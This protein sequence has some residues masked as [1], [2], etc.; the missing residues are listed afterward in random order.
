MIS[1]TNAPPDLVD[2]GA[3]SGTNLATVLQSVLISAVKSATENASEPR[4][5]VATAYFNLDGFDT[6]GEPL[7]QV[8]ELRLLIGTEPNQAFVLTHQLAQELERHFALIRPESQQKLERW[9]AFVRQDK[10]Q[11][12]RYKP[13]KHGEILHGKAYLVF[14]VPI[15]GQLGVIGS[16]NFTGA[17]LTTNLELNAILKQQSAT[18]QLY[19]WYEQLWQQAEDYKAELLAMLEQFTRPLRPY[20]VYI[21]VVYE[22]YRDRLAS[23][24]GEQE[25]RP[26]PIALADFQRDGY[27]AAREI[28]EQYGGVLIADSVGLGKTYLALRLLDDY[29][30]QQR[31]TALVIC[32]AALR[33]TVWKPLLEYH[34]IP[35]RIESMEQISRGDLDLGDLQQYSVIVVDES[36][37]FRNPNANR[38]QNLFQLLRHAS[39]EQ[40]R[41]ILL[42]A[43]PVNNSVYDLYH[44]IRLI[45]RDQKDFFQIAGIDNLESYFRKAEEQRES[46]YELLEAISVRRSRAFIRRRYPDAII[47][48]KRIQFPERHIHTVQYD[49][50]QVYG[51]DLYQRVARTIEELNLAPYQ[52]DSYRKEVVQS[53]L[54]LFGDDWA[55][56]QQALRKAGMSEEQIRKFRFELGGQAALADLMRVLYLKRL[57]SSVEALRNSLRHQLQ[58]Q[59]RFLETLQQGKLLTSQDYRRMLMLEGDDEEEPSED[60]QAFLESLKSTDASQYDLPLV[61][62]A[63]QKDIRTLQTL[64]DELERLSPQNDAKVNTLVNL[65]SSNLQ[66]EKVLIFSYYKDTARMLYSELK[67]RLPHVEIALVDSDVKMEERRRIV[68]RFSPQSNRYTLQSN[69]HEIQILIATDALSEG[70]NLQDA[71]IVINYDLHWNPV[72]MVQ[73]IGRIDRIGSPHKTIDVYNFIPED[74]LEDL[75]GLMQRLL[76]KLGQI[77]RTVGLDAS[78]LGEAP[79]PMD[80]N[81]LRRIAQGEDAVLEALEQEGELNIGEFLMEDLMAY[82]KELGEEHLGRIPLG[83]G[84]AKYA[85]DPNHV[86]FFAAFR[87]TRTERHYWLFQREGGSL[88]T[89]QLRAIQP[90]RSDP[91]EP[92]APL[93]Q[94]DQTEQKLQALRAELVKRLNQQKHRA[95]DL[96]SVQRQILRWLRTLP[97]SAWRNELLQYFGNA[98]PATDLTELRTL[99]REVPKLAP[100]QAMQH[101]KAFAESHPYP[102]VNSTALEETTEEDLECIAWMWVLQRENNP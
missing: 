20:E 7:K 27:Y 14:G 72:R 94:P 63:V 33:D 53:R 59:Q 10:V 2:N 9:A 58:F 78:V 48:G 22:A 13:Q 11:V 42:T 40:T 5:W 12:R 52:I 96:P 65:L 30:Y 44:Q 64:L 4:L 95:D 17:G 15:L 47:D 85:R 67:R 69:E 68:Q 102:P 36:H 18:D 80:F 46:L 31:K 23:N 71:R 3:V 21:K 81:T 41:L 66:G 32:P 70:Q 56:I 55:Q 90:V 54:L 1:G 26:S 98:L 19:Q 51:G 38:W 62:Q 77:N 6:L 86:G 34:A 99:W 82:L 60:L 101:L 91:N 61:E 97:S 88:E 83:R 76:D 39:P 45:T 73:R 8:H 50:Q 37:N 87:H 93:P 35:H 49:L 25:G 74:A 57:E 16:S 84:A 28:L 79:N 92:A 89:A 24:L 75:L 43:T 29:A 100:Q